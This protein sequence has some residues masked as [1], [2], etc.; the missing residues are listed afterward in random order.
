MYKTI[1][2]NKQNKI[3]ESY[4]KKIKL[5]N[6]KDINNKDVLIE[7]ETYENYLKLKDFLKEKNIEIGISSAYRSIE[8]QEKIYNEFLEKYGEEY[9]KT[10]VSNW[11]LA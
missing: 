4:L 2:V 9:T 1:L 8:D 3:K 7:K 11:R 10:Y 6:T 5:I